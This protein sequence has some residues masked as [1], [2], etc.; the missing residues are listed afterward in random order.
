[1][2]N[3]L[4]CSHCGA[5][6]ELDDTVNI[7]YPPA[8]Q[9]GDSNRSEGVSIGNSTRFTWN[10][11]NCNQSS[12]VVFTGKVNLKIK[13]SLT[14]RDKINVSRTTIIIVRNRDGNEG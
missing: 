8:M 3:V 10:C 11:L 12:A 6:K 7:D 5:E 13:G 4:N 1:M 2:A 9:T 14:G